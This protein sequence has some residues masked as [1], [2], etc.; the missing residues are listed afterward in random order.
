M[1]HPLT[2]GNAT[3]KPLKGE[4]IA[5]L[6]ASGVNETEMTAAQRALIETGATIKMIAPDNGLV[7]GWHDNIWGH[8]FA[9]DQGLAQALAADYSTLLVPGGQRAMD[10]L[11]ANPHTARF[12]KGFLMYG[13]P[14]ALF[15]DAV[16]LLA[17]VNMAEGK[18]VA[19]PEAMEQTLR[20]AG[21]TWTSEPMA[22]D[23]NLLTGMS[24]AAE[25]MTGLIA[26]T[27]EHFHNIPDEFRLA[28]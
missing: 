3:D 14:V 9:P 5:I 27:V 18:T 17:H 16:Q 11:K 24:S 26:A 21:A 19:G 7:Q 20:T 12:L 13:K 2:S 8:Y 25:H 28:A 23:T 1:N 10:K 6:I 22:I 15:G 4:T